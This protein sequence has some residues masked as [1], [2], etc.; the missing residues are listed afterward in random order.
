MCFLRLRSV[1]YAVCDARTTKKL[2]RRHGDPA[3]R[4]SKYCMYCAYS[5]KGKVNVDTGTLRKYGLCGV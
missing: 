4:S 5:G 2:P 1:M 3:V